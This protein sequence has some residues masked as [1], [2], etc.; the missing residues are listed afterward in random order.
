M[1][2]VLL[3]DD[4]AAI[5]EM[6]MQGLAGVPELRV[7]SASHGG[8]A[9]AFMER[10]SV[11]VVVTDLRMPV[12]DGFQ[13]VTWISRHRPSLPTIVMTSDGSPEVEAAVEEMGSVDYL[14]KPIYLAVLVGAVKRALGQT[15]GF[16]AG[17][18]LTGFLQLLAVERKT[19]TLTL[20]A[21]GQR[22]LMHFRRGELID[23]ELDEQE[24]EDAAMKIAQWEEA[25]IELAEEVD[26]LRRIETPLHAV[27]MEAMRLKDEAAR[28]ATGNDDPDLTVEDNAPP[29]AHRAIVEARA[30]EGAFAVALI[31]IVGGTVLVRA[32]G[33]PG[34]DL[35]RLAAGAAAVMRAQ[36]D[37]LAAG[38]GASLLGPGDAVEDFVT[39]LA[40]EW[41]VIRPASGGS[42]LFY[43]VLDRA[44]AD[45][46]SARR[47]I[48]D[49][50]KRHIR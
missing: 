3:V 8:E 38:R 47:R 10:E 50:E 34:L 18:S 19:C 46:A 28:K 44:K 30:I 35:S 11:D 40:A 31:E 32:G 15:R 1:H 22:G 29:S 6:L 41:H 16:V 33:R 17:L 20:S 26:R 49:I 25:R 13:L 5:R 4:D 12:M 45:L 48:A 42:L 43:V 2:T 37:A 7:V 24:G 23:A 36:I 9:V 39:T 27:L 14:E 21:E